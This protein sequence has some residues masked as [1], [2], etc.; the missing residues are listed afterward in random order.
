M[1]PSHFAKWS[2][3]LR[4]QAYA[5]CKEMKAQTSIGYVD[6]RHLWQKQQKYVPSCPNQ[7]WGHNIL[8][9]SWMAL[10]HKEMKSQTSIDSVDHRY[11]L[12]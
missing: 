5:V 11:Y 6:D 1:A 9:N 4:L 3:I 12:W 2:I 7:K 8:L 10:G